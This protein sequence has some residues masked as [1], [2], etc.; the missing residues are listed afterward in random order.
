MGPTRPPLQNILT[1]DGLPI[2]QIE[3]E[4]TVTNEHNTTAK[5]TALQL[6]NLLLATVV[7]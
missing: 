4:K 5:Y 2:E 6:P 1:P 3:V 7:V